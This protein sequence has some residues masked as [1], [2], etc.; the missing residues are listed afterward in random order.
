MSEPDIVSTIRA[1]LSGPAVPAESVQTASHIPRIPLSTIRQGGT[2][3]QPSSTPAQLGAHVMPSTSSAMAA[4]PTASGSTQTESPSASSAPS[5]TTA[6]PAI[7]GTPVATQTQSTSTSTA[8]INTLRN[9]MSS[10]NGNPN[11]QR[12]YVSVI[13]S[14]PSMISSSAATPQTAAA[15]TATASTGTSTQS[16]PILPSSSTHP[17]PL[18]FTSL[19]HHFMS[20]WDLQLATGASGF[21]YYVTTRQR[22]YHPESFGAGG[23]PSGAPGGGGGAGGVDPRIMHN[24]NVSMRPHFRSKVVCVLDCKHCGTE[25][26]RRGMKAILLADMNVELFSTDSPPYGVQ[27][28]NDD[29]QTRNCFCRIRDVACL[30]CGN[31]IG[32]HVTQPCEPCMDACNN[33][34]FWMFHVSEVASHDRIV[35]ESG[36]PLVWSQI[37]RADKDNQ[38][39]SLT[40]NILR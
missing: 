30:G 32:Y 13:G 4:A 8:P 15:T 36:Q 28:V 38:V 25:V 16:G 12:S 40:R 5:T 6:T 34:H 22:A 20:P 35:T 21:N 17:N 27:L 3:L 1:I 19:H 2:S 10:T 18:S 37:P 11:H 29:Y 39:E 14:A 31:V 26:C 9:P 24:A 33:G 7:P 23:G